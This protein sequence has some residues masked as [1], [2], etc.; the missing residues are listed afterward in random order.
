MQD[1]VQMLFMLFSWLLRTL[2]MSGIHMLALP[3]GTF[4]A[5][6]SEMLTWQCARWISLSTPVPWRRWVKLIV[7]NIFHIL[8]ISSIS[9]TIF[10]WPSK[11]Y[12]DLLCYGGQLW[13]ASPFISPGD[14]GLCVS[15]AGGYLLRFLKNS[16]ILS[17]R[18]SLELSFPGIQPESEMPF[19]PLVTNPPS[20]TDY[21]IRPHF[22]MGEW[23][24]THL[25]TKDSLKESSFP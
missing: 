6:S 23:K 1:Q 21:P 4:H 16:T 14:T 2:E 11:M 13:W 3:G 5:G 7:F 24:Q 20:K 10:T 8:K 12:T 15:N 25:Q 22:A 17:L 19:C 9:S 18:G